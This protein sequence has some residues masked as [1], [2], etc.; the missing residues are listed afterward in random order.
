MCDRTVG[1]LYDLIPASKD[2]KVMPVGEWNHAR[3][4]SQGI[5]SCVTA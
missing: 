4:L 5:L 3:I 1:S 2:K